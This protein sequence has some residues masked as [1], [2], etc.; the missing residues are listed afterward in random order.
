VQTKVLHNTIDIQ[1]SLI[2]Q[3]KAPK[4]NLGGSAKQSESYFFA[5]LCFTNVT[6]VIS[7]SSKVRPTTVSAARVCV[8]E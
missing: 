3:R 7:S 1:R 6:V 2:I 8:N 5:S 4:H